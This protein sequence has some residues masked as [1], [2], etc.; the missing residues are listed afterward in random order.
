MSYQEVIIDCNHCIF[1]CLSHFC[2]CMLYIC[3]VRQMCLVCVPTLLVKKP[4]GFSLIYNDYIL[5]IPSTCHKPEYV[6]SEIRVYVHWR[7]LQAATSNRYYTRT[8]ALVLFGVLCTTATLIIFHPLR[9]GVSVFILNKL[10]T[11]A[12]CPKHVL[13]F[14]RLPINKL[15][16]PHL[17]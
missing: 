13:Q 2:P 8:A 4:F 15:C 12:S 7:I 17:K 3:P 5:F 10:T 14:Y 9:L 16:S 6:S 11:R 1:K